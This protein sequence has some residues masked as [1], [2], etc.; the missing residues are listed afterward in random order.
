MLHHEDFIIIFT[1]LISL[2]IHYITCIK[3]L[4][5]QSRSSFVRK[6]FQAETFHYLMLL[7]YQDYFHLYEVY[8][9]NLIF[10]I[11]MLLLSYTSMKYSFDSN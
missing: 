7:I 11:F 8:C 1:V 10:P 9:Y 6:T 5:I 3:C 4:L 2:C